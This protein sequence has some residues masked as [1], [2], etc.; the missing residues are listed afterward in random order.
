MKI[1]AALLLLVSAYAVQVQAITLYECSG[2][3][4]IVTNPKDC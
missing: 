1:I 3:G 2:G 4:A